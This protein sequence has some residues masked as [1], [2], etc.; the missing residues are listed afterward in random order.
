MKIILRNQKEHL[1]VV[2]AYSI[3]NVTQSIMILIVTTVVTQTGSH[4]IPV[5]YL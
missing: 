3:W 5:M 1:S 2:L 4:C